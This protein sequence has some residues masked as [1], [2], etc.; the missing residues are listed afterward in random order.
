MHGIM[1]ALMKA[2]LRGFFKKKHQKD[3][4]FHQSTHSLI[5]TAPP[6]SAGGVTMGNSVIPRLSV[7]L[8]IKTA[9]RGI[10]RAN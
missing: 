3:S 4:Q 10:W 2:D 8:P 5:Q 1:H 6:L 7:N 9:G